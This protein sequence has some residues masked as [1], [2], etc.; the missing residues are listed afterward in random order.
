MP[1]HDE[2]IATKTAETAGQPAAWVD[3]VRELE[4]DLPRRSAATFSTTEQRELA[5]TTAAMR[6]CAHRPAAEAAATSS[7]SW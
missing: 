7:T 5:L 1:F 3:Q 4:A 2:R 6:Q